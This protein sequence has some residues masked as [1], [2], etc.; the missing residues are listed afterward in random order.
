MTTTNLSSDQPRATAPSTTAVDL[1]ALVAGNS[2]FAF[3]LYHALRAGDG[4]FFYSP[5]SISLALAMT[6][7]GARAETEQ[8]MAGALR[9]TLPQDRLH[10]AFN[11]LDLALASRGQ[12]ARGKDGGGFRL[13]IANALWGQEGY[14]FLAAFLDTLA[15]NYG[16][17]LRLLDFA[18]A[19]EVSRREINTWISAQTEGRIEE[20][21]PPGLI[22][23]LTR[24]ILTNAIYFNAA[25]SRPFSARNTQEQPFT[26]LDGR[27]VPVPMMRQTEFFAYTAG[28]GYQAVELPYDGRELAMLLLLPDAGQFAAFETAL[29]AE[30]VAGIVARLAGRRL[31]LTMPLYTVESEFSL[32]AVLAALGMPAAFS[33]LAD[34]S[35]IEPQGELSIADVVHKAFVA[36]DE[37]GTEAAAATAVIMMT[38]AMM[39]EDPLVVRVDRPFL[40]LIRDLQTGAILF[41]GRVL[42]PRA[43]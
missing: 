9:F 37:A 14:D 19:P 28:P 33:E 31:D 18:G 22:N 7:A 4:S 40:L 3:D 8:Q 11:A 35:G 16:A 17:G 21:I 24:L 43:A 30:K 25:W 36:V 6:Y 15:L 38:R 27:Q 29:T 10:P 41:V 32:A 42:D 39:P 13:N 20:L 5:Y 2:A 23:S 1:A 34:F 12:G 26:L